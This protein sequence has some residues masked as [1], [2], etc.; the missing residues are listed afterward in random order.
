MDVVDISNEQ[1]ET[2]NNATLSDV[3]NNARRLFDS[4]VPTEV[5]YCAGCGEEIPMERLRAIPG[6][7]YCIFCKE[8]LERGR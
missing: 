6:T 4:E 2:L 1:T 3:Q 5:R 7:K 8:R